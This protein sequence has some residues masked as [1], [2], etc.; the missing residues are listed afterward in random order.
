MFRV[1]SAS[2]SYSE[3]DSMN[4]SIEKIRLVVSYLFNC[5]SNREIAKNVAVSRET[6]AKI[7]TLLSLSELTFDEF[8]E[9]SNSELEEKLK[10]DRSIQRIKKP[11]PDAE[12]FCKELIVHKGLTKA[13]LWEEYR[14]QTEGNGVGYTRF[15]ELIKQAQKQQD[16]SKKQ[17]YY[18]GEII[19]IDYSGDIVDIDLING[20]VIKANIFVGVLPFSDLIFTYATRTQKTEDWIRGCYHMFNKIDGIPKV[21][22]CDNAKALISKHK[23]RIVEINPYFQEF[24]EFYKISV[25]P[26]R[27]RKPRDKALCENAVNIV[28]KQ[29]L[30][31]MR[32]EKFSSL[33]ALNERLEYMTDCYNHKKTKTFPN[34]RMAIFIEQEKIALRPLPIIRYKILEQ[35]IKTVVPLDYHVHYLNNFYS[36]PYQYIIETVELKISDNQICIFHD[37][38]LIAKHI[39]LVGVGKTS[40]KNEHQTEKHKIKDYLSKESILSW[41]KTIG[42]STFNYCNF[43]LQKDS[44]LYSNLNYLFDLRG[45]IMDKEFDNRV[46]E[47]LSYAYKLKIE[48]LSR[49]KAIIESKSYLNIKNNDSRKHKNLRGADYYKKAEKC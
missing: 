12:K 7:K 32:N 21:I 41:S 31:R 23:N 47:A 24:L 18:S 30:M 35:Y 46:E 17:E 9:L 14:L 48:N 10:I 26:A 45:W 44:N 38:K 37:K 13:V 49:L 19:Q 3:V 29:I 8:T 28:Q 22:V 6:V 42:V 2:F 33:D 5:Q 25:L 20:D 16:I 43:I 34:S 36:V 39:L 40:T 1:L 11:Q 15:C 27:P 4:T